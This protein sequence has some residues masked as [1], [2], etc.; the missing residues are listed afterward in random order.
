MRIEPRQREAS[1]S[2]A[3]SRSR[4]SIG[5]TGVND[6]RN[7]RKRGAAK[8]PRRSAVCVIGAEADLAIHELSDFGEHI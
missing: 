5:S 6:A 4:S 7:L 8:F 3:V 2:P 1:E